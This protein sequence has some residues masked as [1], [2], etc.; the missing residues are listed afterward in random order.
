VAGIWL[1][2]HELQKLPTAPTALTA[3]IVKSLPDVA[4]SYRDGVVIDALT[5]L[6]ANVPAP[7]NVRAAA[8]RAIAARPNVKSLGPV[9]GG[10]ALQIPSLGGSIRLVV[11]PAT[12][13][14]HSTGYV[15]GHGANSFTKG[16]VT[17]LDAE[18]TN[19]LPKAG[20]VPHK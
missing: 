13:I 1:T 19:A 17:V 11:D 6:L 4:A 7:P 14:V 18:W 20:P 12:S 2:F 3:W 15:V 16:I 10:Q 5:S 9:A 8:F